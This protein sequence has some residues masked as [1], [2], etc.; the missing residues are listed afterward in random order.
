VEFFERYT[1]VACL[2]DLLKWEIAL[3]E[4]KLLPKDWLE[5]AW[6]PYI[7]KDGQSTHYGYGW[8]I[9]SYNDFRLLANSGVGVNPIATAYVP[10]KNI[11]IAYTQL[12]G[13]IEQAEIIV[14]KILSR[15][16]P[17]PYPSPRKAEMPLT[18][19]TGVYQIDRIGFRTTSQLSDVPI[20]M[21]ITT[22]GDTLYMQ[23][24]GTEKAMLRPAGKDKFLPAR[25]E[26][27]FFIFIRNAD[28]KVNAITS[29]G[30]LWTYGQEVLNKKVNVTWPK[31]VKAKSISKDFLQK[32]AGTYS[33]ASVNVYRFIETDGV[34]LFE[35]IQG[36]LQELIPVTDNKFVRKGVED[37][38]F[39]FKPN[40]NNVLVLTISGLRSIDYKKIN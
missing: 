40:S 8:Y 17:L 33:L 18:D 15:M 34:K 3:R 16:V 22:S 21:N 5:K 28:G 29:E 20:Y 32:Y 11:Y 31:P 25:S 36:K 27:M 38:S 9:S 30:S 19:Y 4:E 13:S 2:D 1:I 10:E 24:T 39:E 14:K 26:N 37:I 35:R 6:K 23:Q 7:L 12:Y